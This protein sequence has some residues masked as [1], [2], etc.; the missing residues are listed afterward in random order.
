MGLN[1]KISETNTVKYC[2]VKMNNIT[3]PVSY[4]ITIED[5]EHNITITP[6]VQTIPDGNL[7]ATGVYKL[8]EGHIG[9]GDIV[10]D[11]DMNQWEYTGMGDLTH[12]E[13]GRIADYIRDYKAPYSTI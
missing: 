7:H 12:K 11:D 4:T 8:T 1:H 6:V 9:M 10:F 5:V 3:K 2:N 13:A